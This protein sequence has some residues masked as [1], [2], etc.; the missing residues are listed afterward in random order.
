[1]STL[2]QTGATHF[3]HDLLWP[4]PPLATTSFGHRLTDFG[5]GQLWAFLRVGRGWGEG[6]AKGAEGV[7]A[8][9]QKNG[10][11]P[12]ISCFF[13]PSPGHMFILFLSLSGMFSCLFFSLRVSSRVFLSLSGGLLVE[14]WSCF[15][16]SRP[17]IYLFSPLGC[18]VEAPGGLQATP[19]HKHGLY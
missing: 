15:G 18:R 14:F 13:F 12:K 1:M 16:R 19:S 3:G 5:H 7:G 4:R 10:G 6:G 2:V 17:Q 9:T 11:G 8:R